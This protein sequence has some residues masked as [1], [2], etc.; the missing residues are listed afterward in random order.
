MFITAFTLAGAFIVLVPSYAQDVVIAPVNQ[1]ENITYVHISGTIP[2]DPNHFNAE[3]KNVTMLTIYA[4]GPYGTA[5][6]TNPATDGNFSMNVPGAGTYSIW[7]LPSRLDYLNH[8]TNQTYSIDY[9]DN[10]SYP[11]TVNVTATGLSGISIPTKTVVTGIA[12]SVTPVPL[13]LPSPTPSPGFTA[14]AV[15]AAIGVLAAAA[16]A[17]YRKK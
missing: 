10:A 3:V 1:T 6:M 9:P 7:V 14:M 2:Y 5:N 15:L 16:G 12:M 13:S 4:K 11:F 8:T 17:A